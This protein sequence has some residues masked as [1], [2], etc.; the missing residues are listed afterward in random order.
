MSAIW[1]RFIKTCRRVKKK[2][3]GLKSCSVNLALR[4]RHQR[5]SFTLNGVTSSIAKLNWG[6][7]GS[8]H[9]RKDYRIPKTCHWYSF[10]WGGMQ[11]LI[12]PLNRRKPRLLTERANCKPKLHKNNKFVLQIWLVNNNVVP[13]STKMLIQEHVVLGKIRFSV[14][15]SSSQNSGHWLNHYRVLGLT[16]PHGA[17]ACHITTSV[18][19]WYTTSQKFLLLI[20]NAFLKNWL[21]FTKPA[22]IWSKIQKKNIVKYF[23]YLI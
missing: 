20:F 4:R 14:Y 5:L 15:C 12:W 8:L 7:V 13:G 9:W 19:L 2:K 23:Y 18:S 21:L 16:N 10:E 3:I 1:W 6:S 11:C 22:F 17:L